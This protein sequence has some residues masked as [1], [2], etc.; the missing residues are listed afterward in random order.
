[1]QFFSGRELKTGED[2]SST[3][4]V[5]IEDTLA[6]LERIF[7][8]Q[9]L[10]KFLLDVAVRATDST[11]GSIML[12]SEDARELYIAYAT[13]L[14]ERIIRNTRQ[15]IGKGIAGEVAQRKEPK[16]IRHPERASLYAKDRDRTRISSAISMPLIQEGQL[17]GVL[18]VSTDRPGRLHDEGDLERLKTLSRRLARVLSQSL[19]LD[20]LKMRH[21]ESRFRNTMAELAVKQVSTREK[22]AILS[23]YLADIVGAELAEIYINTLEGDWFVLGGSSRVLTPTEERVRVQKG[24]LGRALLERRTIVLTESVGSDDDPMQTVSSMVYTF[25]PLDEAGGV[26]AMEFNARYRL[27]EFL[28]IREAIVQEVTRF[29]TAE[30]RERRL[31]REVRAFAR[32]SDAAAPLLSCRSLDELTRLLSRLVADILECDRVSVRLK[33]ADGDPRYWEGT[34]VPPG[35]PDEPWKT[36]DEERF[37]KLS[38]IRKPFTLAFLQFDDEIRDEAG[39]SRSVMAVPVQEGSEFLGG[40]IAYDKRPQ[41]PMEDALFSEVDRRV[42]EH[43]GRL[44]QPVIESIRTREPDAATGGPEVYDTIIRANRERFVKLTESEISRSDRY[45]HSFALIM[46]DIRRLERLFNDDYQ[47]ALKLVDEV[48]RGIA[49]RTRKSDYGTWIARSRYVMLSLEGGPRI[50]F[51]IS[52]AMVY[53]QKDLSSLEGIGP[54]DVLVGNATYPGTVRSAEELLDEAISGLE[55]H[56]S[57]E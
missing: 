26:L 57:A 45:H 20:A 34:I 7:D 19:K 4:G 37:E 6:A 54:D 51:L 3:N 48:T 44:V 8:R 46:F 33:G 52:R 49:T 10:L 16:L 50:R 56:D 42:V 21:R 17:L 47:A 41:D 32:V 38:K 35:D 2:E 23:S 27:D 55:S 1:M 39:S 14:S 11:A 18:N 28:F 9:E 13:G 22:L 36:E 43:I 40:V 24:A 25:L 29:V 30:M 12:Y 53:L 5:A 15:E 31:R